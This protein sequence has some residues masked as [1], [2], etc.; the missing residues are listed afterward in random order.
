MSPQIRYLAKKTW[1]E[2]LILGAFAKVSFDNATYFDE[3]EQQHF[4]RG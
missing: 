1:D 2:V 4:G 3:D